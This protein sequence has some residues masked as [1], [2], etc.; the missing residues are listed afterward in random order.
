MPWIKVKNKKGT[1]GRQPSEADSWLEFWKRRKKGNEQVTPRCRAKHCNEK[2]TLGAHVVIVGEEH[3]E[4][5]VPLCDSCNQ[6]GDEFE[7]SDSS[8]VSLA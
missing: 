4:Y 7:V 5:I 2:A 3:K 1:A 6:L 8:L